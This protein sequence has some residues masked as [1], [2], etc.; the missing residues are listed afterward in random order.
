MSTTIHAQY[1]EK[2]WVEDFERFRALEARPRIPTWIFA[3]S[4]T[5]GH[6]ASYAQQEAIEDG[7]RQLRPLVAERMQKYVRK[8]GWFGSSQPNTAEVRE[9]LRRELRSRVYETD[10]FEQKFQQH[11]TTVWWEGMLINASE[12][13]LDL[14]AQRCAQG[15][16]RQEWTWART[17]GSAAGLLGVVCVVYGVV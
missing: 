10:R 1:S 3:K 5:A 16:N 9:I 8:Q 7:M 14:L 4:Q 2:P 13:N 15:G 11:G 17:A 6:K 12:R